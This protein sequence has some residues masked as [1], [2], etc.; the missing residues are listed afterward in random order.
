MNCRTGFGFKATVPG[1]DERRIA[2][3]YAKPPMVCQ[4]KIAGHMA[5]YFLLIL[6]V[7]FTNF[8][9]TI[10]YHM[11]CVNGAQYIC[12]KNSERR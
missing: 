3:Q 9:C 5:C 11:D 8:K 6:S 10:E 7:D 4:I 1:A 12:K 2:K